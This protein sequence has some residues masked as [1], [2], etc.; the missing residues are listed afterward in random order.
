MLITIHLPNFRDKL[1]LHVIYLLLRNV[2]CENIW[3]FNSQYKGMEFWISFLKKLIRILYYICT[4]FFLCLAPL[5]WLQQC[6][7]G[8]GSIYKYKSSFHGPL[9]CL[10]RNT[11][12]TDTRTLT[13]YNKKDDLTA[14]NKKWKIIHLKKPRTWTP[15]TFFQIRLQFAKAQEWK[16]NTKKLPL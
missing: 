12:P 3:N 5:G 2:S 11:R 8:C 6:D 4:I 7:V 13:I 16:K 1:T 9:E 15:I 14:T 10:L